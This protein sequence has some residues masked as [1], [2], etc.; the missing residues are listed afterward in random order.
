MFGT[1]EIELYNFAQENS[2]TKQTLYS[3]LLPPTVC[4]IGFKVHLEGH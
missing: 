2:K 1:G 4:F 3:I